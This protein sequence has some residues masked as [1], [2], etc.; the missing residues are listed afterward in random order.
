MSEYRHSARETLLLFAQPRQLVVFFLGVAQG[1]PNALIS[2]TLMFWLSEVGRNNSEVGLFGFAIAAYALKPLWA[3]FL[4]QFDVPM[5]GKWLGSRRAWLLVL[6]VLLI[7]AITGLGMTDPAHGLMA[8]AILAATIGFLSASQDILTDA[9]RIEILD[10]DE[11][12][13]GAAMVQF[14]W[15][16]GALMT[17]AG[18]LLMADQFGYSVAF[19]VS[20]FFILPGLIAVLWWGEPEHVETPEARRIREDSEAFLADHGVGGRRQQIIAKLNITIVSPFR[21]FM[22]RPGWWLILLFIPLFKLGDA[23]GLNQFS[24]FLVDL[25]FT[26]TE[27]ALANKA[28]GLPPLLLGIAVGGTIYY[29]LGT[30]RALV[31]AG[32]MMMVTNLAFVWL[33]GVGHS[34]PALM[35]TVGVENFAS[36]VGGTAVV[37]YLSSLCNRSFTASQYA[38]L[39]GFSLLPRGIFAGF[40]GFLSERVSWEVFWVYSTLLAIP[41]LL[42]LFAMRRIAFDADGNPLRKKSG[43]ENSGHEAA[44]EKTL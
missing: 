42:M 37:A 41:G 38:L 8:T 1:A 15:R 4:D 5:L 2:A 36:G 7:A 22:S 39:A 11:Q 33:A 12:G 30:F 31:V 14:G 23:V 29:A 10:D 20:A 40:S 24:P 19:A 35:V 3:P 32:V 21:E 27:S 18:T 6:Q 34:V 44:E 17:G 26:A 25:G 9:F 43:H 28:A 13:A 16:V